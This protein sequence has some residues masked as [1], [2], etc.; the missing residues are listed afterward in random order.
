MKFREIISRITGFSIPIFGIQW[1]P[2]EAECAAAKRVL[3]FLEDRR[4]LYVP[5]EMEV[6]HY[7]VVVDHPHTRVPD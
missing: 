2:P 5:S 3:T 7:C 4:V 6:P 1:N